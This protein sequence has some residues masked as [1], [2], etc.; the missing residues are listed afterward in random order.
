[1][2]FYSAFYIS[3]RLSNKQP[4]AQATAAESRGISSS[5]IVLRFF[6]SD[7]KEECGSSFDIQCGFPR[8]TESTGV[9]TEP[10]ILSA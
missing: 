2:V 3:R 1:M 7:T 5:E 6:G 4:K 8:K 10:F 9:S